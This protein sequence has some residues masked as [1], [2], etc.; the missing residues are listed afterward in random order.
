MKANA[1]AIK[2]AGVVK[3]DP[4]GSLK[5]FLFLVVVLVVIFIVF[6]L[7]KG[8]STAADAV[9]DLVT[10]DA[11]R[12]EVMSDS[13]YQDA[14]TWL[15]DQ[16]GMVAIAKKFGKK[17]TIDGYLKSIN[18]PRSQFGIV[19]G[20]IADARLAIGFYLNG[21]EVMQAIAS[22]PTKTTISLMAGVFNQVYG[23]RTG[24]YPLN[25]FLGK[26]L[27]VSEMQTLAKIINSKKD[28]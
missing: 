9:G 13:G 14:L 8:I 21:T 26:Y 6:K 2:T 25:T 7:V 24:Y 16:R 19:A 3:S 1:V 23:N 22:L 18:Y 20:Q 27:S 10:T 4:V 12:A 5:A 11:E 28:I 17:G 15:G